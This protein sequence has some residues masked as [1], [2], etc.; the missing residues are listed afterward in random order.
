M[1]SLTKCLAKAGK[2]IDESDRKDVLARYEAHVKDGMPASDAAELA[3]RETHESLREQLEQIAASAASV[4]V[5]IVV[6]EVIDPDAAGNQQT[7]PELARLE[8][9]TP[10]EFAGEA[11]MKLGQV[12]DVYRAPAIPKTANTIDKAVRAGV[13]EAIK[14]P[15]PDHLAAMQGWDPYAGANT[16]EAFATSGAWRDVILDTQFKA[17]A[18]QMPAS[19]RTGL[20]GGVF[21]IKEYLPN[22]AFPSGAIE[23]DVSGLGT[24]AEGSKIY[25]AAAGLA[26][27]K[28][29]PFRADS[30]GLKNWGA[31][32]RTVTMANAAMRYG[33]QFVEPGEVQ[34]K[35]KAAMT[36]VGIA[37]LEWEV[38]GIGKTIGRNEGSSERSRKN[39]ANLL[40]TEMQ[41]VR[42]VVGDVVDQYGFDWQAMRFTKNGAPVSFAAGS[43]EIESLVNLGEKTARERNFV[44]ENPMAEGRPEGPA[45]SSP[46]YGRAS[47][48]RAVLV[49]SLARINGAEARRDA[50]ARI[51]M[52]VPE[53]AGGRDAAGERAPGEAG[54]EAAAAA[55]PTLPADLRRLWSQGTRPRNPVRSKQQAQTLLRAAWGAAFNRMYGDGK[56]GILRLVSQQEAIALNKGAPGASTAKGWHDAKTGVTYVVWDNNTREEIAGTMLHEAGVHLAAPE[57]LGDDLY[58]AA[59]NDLMQR[60]RSGEDAQAAEALQMAEAA[61]KDANGN[62]I[63]PDESVPH[64]TLAYLAEMNPGDGIVTRVL[65]MLK[66]TLNRMGFR[67]TRLESDTDLLLRVM[68][69]SLRAKARGYTGQQVMYQGGEMFADAPVAFSQPQRPPQPQQP[70]RRDMRGGEQQWR[71]QAKDRKDTNPKNL[72]PGEWRL[73]FSQRIDAITK[74]PK[75]KKWAEDL[76]VVKDGTQYSGQ[77][78]VIAAYHGSTHG[79]IEVFE[80]VG[81]AEG[82][83]G[84]GPYFTTSPEDASANYAGLGPDLAFRIEKRAEELANLSS[85]REILEDYFN[86][87]PGIERPYDGDLDDD[88][89]YELFQEYGQNALYDVARRE[90]VGKALGVVYPVFVKTKKP[91][92]IATSFPTKVRTEEE[93]EAFMA[94]MREVNEELGFA[95]N[96]AMEVVREE[97]EY[98]VQT[99]NPASHWNVFDAIVRSNVYAYDEDRS[100]LRAGGIFRRIAKRAG[101]DAVVM[102]AGANFWSMPGVTQST[103]HVVSLAPDKNVKSSLGNTKFGLRDKRFMWSQRTPGQKELFRKSGMPVDDRGIVQRAADKVRD[104]WDNLRAAWYG[105]TDERIQSIA[106]RF[107][108]IGAAEEKIE[109]IIGRKLEANERSYVMARMN[110]G[111]PSILDAVL[112]YGAP[113]FED[114]TWTQWAE[115]DVP[116]GGTIEVSMAA[117]TRRDALDRLAQAYPGA[118]VRPLRKPATPV[119]GLPE[120]SGMTGGTHGVFVRNEDTKGLLDALKPVANDINGWLAWMVTQRAKR[121]KAQGRENLL[122][123]ADIAAGDS[124]ADTPEKLAAFQQA[125]EEYERIKT[126]ILDLAEQA[127]II[128]REGREAWDHAEYIPFFRQSADD[129]LAKAGVIGPRTSKRMTDNRP[130]IR[131]LKGGEEVLADPLGN[132][133]RNFAKLI[134]ASMKNVALQRLVTNLSLNVDDVDGIRTR[135]EG[136]KK[137]VRPDQIKRAFAKV[138][139]YDDATGQFTQGSA[140]FS[141]ADLRVALRDAGI[142]SEQINKAMGTADADSAFFTR[143]NMEVTKALVPMSTV[144][145]SLLDDGVPQAVIDQMPPSALKGLREMMAFRMPQGPDVFT[146][147]SGG[148]AQA[149]KATD[150]LLIRSMVGMMPRQLGMVNRMLAAPARF[151][152]GMITRDPVFMVRNLTRDVMQNWVIS[153]VPYE[154]VMASTRGI[155]KSLMETGG[156]IDMMFAGASFHRGHAQVHDPDATASAIRR[157][158]RAKGMSQADIDSAVAKFSQSI[159]DFGRDGLE[160]WDRVGSAVENATREAV[161]EAAVRAGMTRADASYMARDV[162]DFGLRGDSGVINW[163]ADVLPFFNARI[164]GLY[165]LYRAGAIPG[166]GAPMRAAVMGRAMGLVGFSAGLMAMNLALFAE[167][168][169]ELEEWD[170]DTYWHIA[171]GTAAHVRIPKPFEIGLIFGTIPER[172]LRAIQNQ[173]TGG[174]SGDTAKQS[175]MALWGGVWNTL[176]MNPIPQAFLPAV[177]VGLMNKSTFTGR[178]IENL[179]DQKQPKADIGE[180]YTSPIAKGMAEGMGEVLGFMGFTPRAGLSAK[181]IEHLWRGYTGTIGVYALTA[182]DSI[183]NRLSGSPTVADDFTDWA[184]SVAPAD[185]PFIPGR[186]TRPIADI[187]NNGD[188]RD[189]GTPRNFRQMQEF[190]ALSDTMTVVA[191]GVKAQMERAQEAYEAGE[192]GAARQF[193]EDAQRRYER[194]AGLLGEMQT[195]T[196]KSG[197]LDARVMGGVRFENQTAM[198]QA[199]TK[200]RAH[201]NEIELV[202]TNPDLSAVEQKKRIEEISRARKQVIEEMLAQIKASKVSAANEEKQ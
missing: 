53:Q 5:G 149:Y 14:I 117:P 46:P 143:V 99:D 116:G 196:T 162:M 39:F 171:P 183:V 92:S 139:L 122:T 73:R 119:P 18:F 24:G 63:A 60:A 87:N 160:K 38:R 106:D 32:R 40:R 4:N 129:P 135:L 109:Q 65:D 16:P 98:G 108:G 120:K 103:M 89:A 91:A 47:I 193:E 11:M 123:D 25:N 169:E 173:Y 198:N 66:G 152:T 57:M 144:I 134:D 45:R 20:P 190:Y 83:L 141:R 107:R 7:D 181:Q 55:K 124:L 86:A 133:M 176:G 101:Y 182:A 80:E 59:V 84:E 81:S 58:T 62:R 17:S 147:L 191:M 154:P 8:A 114:Q 150:P 61:L 179:G 164:Q 67:L 189:G 69:E 155:V 10:F 28:G 29:M 111:L 82:F 37:P 180:W 21:I 88:Q 138:G 74:D 130:G 115:V 151:V 36:A 128:S 140:E 2:A 113:R 192:F 157:V 185:I 94:A 97:L 200:L 158:M 1:S 163:L 186:S 100:L 12:D 159:M 161:F 110:L 102:D 3:I 172:M 68:R 95:L 27:A 112:Q 41:S 35:P 70:S 33:V 167:G 72:Q 31:L 54:T 104:E 132:I 187:V 76:P 93:V 202:M 44:P 121:T 126:G 184:L 142:G 43:A 9:M 77:P 71:Q 52:L 127:G 50:L 85:E 194:N 56:T 175:L 178:P 145:Q 79:D 168:Y 156:A 78:A 201:R 96:D 90:L 136:F 166:M 34:M 22:E 199:V 30:S 15:L 174:E 165:K 42:Q 19:A 75:F 105:G 51:G 197:K 64:E 6:S 26:A 49:Q 23:V 13:P 170:K 125:A 148:K 146:V 195:A 48:A 131:V 153:E 118:T 188:W 177:E 137:T